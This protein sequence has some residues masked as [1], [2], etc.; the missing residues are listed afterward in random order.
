MRDETRAH[1]AF[2]AARLEQEKIVQKQQ[3]YAPALMVLALIDAGLGNKQAALE[4]GRRAQ[5]LLPVEKDSINAQRLVAY[6]GIIAAWVGDRD[7][8][9][10]YLTKAASS[11]GSADITSYGLLKLLPFWEPLRGDAR[12]EKVVASVAPKE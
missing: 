4:E 11:P 10:D 5:E 12:F 2:T 8:A 9:L 3:S 6:F 1:A 7:T